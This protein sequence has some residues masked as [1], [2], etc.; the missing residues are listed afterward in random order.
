MHCGI[1]V[2]QGYIASCLMFQIRDL[3][4][5]FLHKNKAFHPF[6]IS[7]VDIAFSFSVLGLGEFGGK[8]FSIVVPFS[9]L[10]RLVSVFVSAW[11]FYG[12]EGA[13]QSDSRFPVMW[14]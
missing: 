14:F 10:E 8:L 2:Y 6:R 11:C 7:R 5:F 12:M 4:I 1:T 3:L 9:S 13:V